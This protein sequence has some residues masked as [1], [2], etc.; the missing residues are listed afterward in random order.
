MTRLVTCWIILAIALSAPASFAADKVNAEYHAARAAYVSLSKDQ[1]RQRY[2]HNWDKVLNKLQRFVKN[3]PRHSKAASAC[4]LLGK[5]YRDL[6]RISRSRKDAEQAVAYFKK[7]ARDYSRS[8]LADDALYIQ[9]EIETQILQHPDTA[10]L[11]CNN[12][13][14]RYPG[15]DKVGDARKLLKT[16]PV[17]VKAQH[18]G[19]HAVLKK[20]RYFSDKNHTRVVMDLDKSVTFVINTLAADKKSGAMARIYLDL[21]GVKTADSVEATNNVNTPIVKRIRVGEHKNLTRVVCDVTRLTEYSVMTLHNPERII[22]DIAQN[23]ATL[24]K[25]PAKATKT[26]A[27][28][29]K[30]RPKTAAP[31]VIEDQPM[32]VKLPDVSKKRRGQLRIVVDPGHGGKDPGA[33]GPGRL[34]EKTVVLKIAREVAARLKKELKCDVVLTRSTDTYIPLQRRTAFAN[35]V[36]ADLFISIHANSSRNHKAH[37]VATYYLNFSK[38]HKA[39]AVA[40]RENGMSLQDVGDLELILFDLMANAKINESSRLAAQIQ[41]SLTGELRR[42]YSNVKNLGVR[43][44]PFYVLLGAT[45]PSVLV[46]VAFISNQQEARRLNSARFRQRAARGIVAGVKKY[47]RTQNLLR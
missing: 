4:Y 20:V 19:G 44:G 11:L 34:Y 45:M 13:M 3:H 46:E 10:R 33:I 26:V 22:V 30:P 6:Y 31:V 23:G 24:E 5:G 21:R 35:K 1:A 25:K 12:I 37:G 36:H 18:G 17:K 32:R 38:N 15:G 8:S 9:A 27:K 43:Q 16:L 42:H 41:Q 7:L 40:A 47:L 39:V 14:C 2:R 29:K 28:K